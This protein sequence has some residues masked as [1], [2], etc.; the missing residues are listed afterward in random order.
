V[1]S[2]PRPAPARYRAALELESLE[3]TGSTLTWI[4]GGSTRTATL[5]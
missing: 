5:D 3:L 4:N 2:R 1:V